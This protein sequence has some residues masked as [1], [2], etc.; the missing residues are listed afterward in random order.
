M[1]NKF[2]IIKSIRVNYTPACSAL[3]HAGRISPNSQ[4]LGHRT[5]P[6]I[7]VYRQSISSSDWVAQKLINHNHISCKLDAKM[8]C[9]HANIMK[10][11]WLKFR[12]HA[13]FRAKKIYLFRMNAQFPSKL[14]SYW[15]ENDA[16]FRAKKV[17]SCK[18]TQL[19]CKRIDCFVETLV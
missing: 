12:I 14:V 18:I 10:K 2:K 16:K 1:R 17:I 9:I 13:K 4:V 7:T 5:V 15:Y 19:L 11:F 8:T 3:T 6:T